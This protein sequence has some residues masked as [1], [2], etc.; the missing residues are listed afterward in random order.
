LHCYAP[1][2]G[3]EAE[4]FS[5]GRVDERGQLSR[6]DLEA[7]CAK[8]PTKAFRNPYEAVTIAFFRVE[9]LLFLSSRN[10]RVYAM[11]RAISF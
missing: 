7:Q 8:V 11:Q 10:N 6:T 9:T 2:F 3:S 1:E 4:A 5:D